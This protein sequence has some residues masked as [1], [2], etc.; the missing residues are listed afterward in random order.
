MPGFVN[1]TGNYFKSYKDSYYL[2]VVKGPNK[3]SS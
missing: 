2:V 3:V 1:A